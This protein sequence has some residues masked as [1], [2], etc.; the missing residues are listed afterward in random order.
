MFGIQSLHIFGKIFIAKYFI[1]FDVRVH[2]I[3]ILRM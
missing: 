1:L 2:K 3:L